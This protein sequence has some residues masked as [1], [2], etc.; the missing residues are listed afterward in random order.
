MYII[1]INNN[2]IILKMT[3]EAFWIPT[4]ILLLRK[5]FVSISVFD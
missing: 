1:I 2:V 4:Q 5:V 3:L